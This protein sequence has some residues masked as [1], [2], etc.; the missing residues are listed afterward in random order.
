MGYCIKETFNNTHSPSL[1][2]IL[3]S[4]TRKNKGKGVDVV[5]GAIIN[6]LKS[7]AVAFEFGDKT[8]KT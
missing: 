3:S 4:A 7:D 8:N 5:Y 6:A 2:S 1:V